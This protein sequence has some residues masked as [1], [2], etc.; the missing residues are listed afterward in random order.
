MSRVAFYTFGILHESMEHPQTKGFRDRLPFVFAGAENSEGFVGRA[1]RPSEEPGPRW[2]ERQTHPR[3][4]F[5]DRHPGAPATISLWD[6][7]ES[8]YAFAYNGRH[9]EALGKRE[10]WFRKPEWPTYV[11]WWVVVDHIPTREEG[12]TH[13]EHLHDHGSTYYAFD[14]KTLFSADGQPCRMDRDRIRERAEVVKQ[15]AANDPLSN[16][17]Y[18][19]RQRCGS[20]Q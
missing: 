9:A 20:L 13:L 6:D 8:V 2:G 7:L 16:S 10:E 19:R 5:E 17:H 4:F 12:A 3:F 15:F 11:A 1:P 18:P 14:F